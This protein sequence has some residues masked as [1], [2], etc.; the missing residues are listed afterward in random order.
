MSD[1]S[2]ED[3]L[4]ELGLD[5]SPVQRRTLTAAEERVIAGFEEIKAFVLEQGRIPQDNPDAEIF[6]RL[7]AVRL[8]RLRSLEEYK[9]LLAQYDPDGLL[10]PPQKKTDELDPED[11]SAEELLSELGLDEEDNS[12]TTLTHVR[13]TDERRAAEKCTPREVPRF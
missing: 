3:M 7:Y 8:N 1:Q 12:L 9:D 11:L 6:E 5:T 13:T 10:A 4:A 2:P